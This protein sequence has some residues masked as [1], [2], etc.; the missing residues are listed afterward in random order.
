MKL[1]YDIIKKWFVIHLNQFEN[2][3]ITSTNTIRDV[4]LKCDKKSDLIIKVEPKK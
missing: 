4:V 2:L 1:Y 3:K